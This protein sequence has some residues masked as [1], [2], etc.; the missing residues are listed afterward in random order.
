MQAE[1]AARVLSLCRQVALSV[2]QLASEVGGNHEQVIELMK[3]LRSRGLLRRTVEKRRHGRPAHLLRTT[4]LG[5][6]FVE[7]YKR[8]MHM[9]L[10]CNPN[11]IQKALRQAELTQRLSEQV[12]VYARFQEVNELTRNIASATQAIRSSR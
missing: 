11:D 6:A 3:E 12:S 1:H 5:E 7:D 8:L 4:P 9:R 10:L 2:S